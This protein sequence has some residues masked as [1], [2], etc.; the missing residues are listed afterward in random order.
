MASSGSGLSNDEGLESSDVLK[1]FWAPSSVHQDLAD[2]ARLRRSMWVRPQVVQR[3]MESGPSTRD[4][5][6]RGAGHFE[7]SSQPMVD[8]T[9]PEDDTMPEDDLKPERDT[10]PETMDVENSQRNWDDEQASCT[11]S[12]VRFDEDALEN[13]REPLAKK[14]PVVHEDLAGSFNNGHSRSDTTRLTA[15]IVTTLTMMMRQ[16]G[17]SGFD[18]KLPLVLE[19]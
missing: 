11:K 17:S 1:F 2:G 14:T 8:G 10:K 6:M 15:V 13:E 16:C 19:L 4:S 18:T 3:A 12:R 5:V 7:S 9:K